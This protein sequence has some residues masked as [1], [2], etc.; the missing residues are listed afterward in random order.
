DGSLTVTAPPATGGYRATVEALSSDGQTSAQILGK[1]LPPVFSYASAAAPSFYTTPGS[2]PAGTDAMI[3][4]TGI[5]SNFIDGQ[6]SVGFGSSDVTVRRLWV[7]NPNRILVN[8]SVNATAAPILTTITV[9]S[10]LQ[11]VTLT[12]GFQILPNSGQTSIHVPIVNAVNGA[13]SVP[14]GGSALISLTG[15]FNLSSATLT[16]DGQKATFT[17]NYNN[18][19]LAQIPA[20]VATGPVIVR[21]VGPNGEVVPPVVMQI[22]PAPAAPGDSKARK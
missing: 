2:L 22:D 14:L 1:A 4:V 7:I 13:N 18:Q 16:I 6:T 12:S 15:P 3:E 9:T 11:L 10:G 5:N 21:L 8:V 17:G 20:G 19:L